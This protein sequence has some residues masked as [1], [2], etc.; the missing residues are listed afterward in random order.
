MPHWISIAAGSSLI[1]YVCCSL[2]N[3]QA[4]CRPGFVK[5]SGSSPSVCELCPPN[6]YCNGRDAYP[7][8]CPATHMSVQGSSRCCP[9]GITLECPEGYAISAQDCRCTRIYCDFEMT[10]SSGDR[11]LKSLQIEASDGNGNVKFTCKRNPQCAPCMADNMVQDP[12]TCICARVSRCSHPQKKI[13]KAES[14]LNY[15][16]N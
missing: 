4:E 3:A 1:L 6:F 5:S 7:R 12:S 15:F 13:W 14:S 9:K 10:P 11:I 8:Q 2:V 16:C